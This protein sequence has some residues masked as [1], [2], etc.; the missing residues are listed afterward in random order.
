MPSESQNS[1]RKNIRHLDHGKGCPWAGGEVWWYW[2][3]AW[4]GVTFHF[5]ILVFTFFSSGRW[6]GK[7]TSWLDLKLVLEKPCQP[8]SNI[9]YQASF[10]IHVFNRLIESLQDVRKDFA[11]VRKLLW[12]W[13]WKMSTWSGGWWGGKTESWPARGNGGFTLYCQ[14]IWSDADLSDLMLSC[15]IW[16]WFVWSDADLLH[17]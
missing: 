1:F 5:G 12:I 3:K 4:Q 15:L 16:C 6:P 7:L 11:E 17:N 8:P 14:N 13:N 9:L 2:E 10:L